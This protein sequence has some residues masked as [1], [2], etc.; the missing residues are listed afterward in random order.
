[1]VIACFTVQGCTCTTT[2][3]A[4]GAAAAAVVGDPELTVNHCL[5]FL[6]HNGGGGGGW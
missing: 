5:S 4:A 3:S 6:D 2:I 1:M